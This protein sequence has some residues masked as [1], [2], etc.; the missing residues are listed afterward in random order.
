M[1][2]FSLSLILSAKKKK[3]GGG[4]P[5]IRDSPSSFL[6]V[7]TTLLSSPLPSPLS[8]KKRRGSGRGGGEGESETGISGPQ[9][10]PFPSAGWALVSPE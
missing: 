5:L 1:R 6:R 9:T 10:M 8:R 4:R 3:G 7:A 2:E